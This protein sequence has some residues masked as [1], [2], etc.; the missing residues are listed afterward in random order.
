LSGQD[1]VIFNISPRG[2]RSFFLISFALT[3]TPPHPP[4]SIKFFDDTLMTSKDREDSFCKRFGG[5]REYGEAAD[6][7]HDFGFKLSDGMKKYD[8]F[9]SFFPFGLWDCADCGWGGSLFL[10]A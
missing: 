5:F 9:W 10:T 8:D 4:L 1:R 7:A 2:I 6:D 3:N